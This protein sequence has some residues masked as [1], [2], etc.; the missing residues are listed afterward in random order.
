M[1]IIRN[2]SVMNVETKDMAGTMVY[3]IYKDLV[4]EIE[5]NKRKTVEKNMAKV[6]ASVHKRG[7]EVVKKNRK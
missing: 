1:I 3:Q 4:N 6:V 7:E 2:Q 5:N